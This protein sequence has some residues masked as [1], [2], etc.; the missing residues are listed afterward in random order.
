MTAIYA[1]T[2]ELDPGYEFW[3]FTDTVLVAGTIPPEALAEALA[4]FQPDNIV[5]AN[6]DEIGELDVRAPIARGLGYDG[7]AAQLFIQ[8]DAALRRG[9]T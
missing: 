6:P 2:S 9:L 7:T 4:T 1:I 3:P 5:L 8:T